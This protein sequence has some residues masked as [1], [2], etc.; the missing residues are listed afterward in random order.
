M[1]SAGFSSERYAYMQRTVKPLVSAE[2]SHDYDVV[3]EEE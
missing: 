2:H 3:L 1:N